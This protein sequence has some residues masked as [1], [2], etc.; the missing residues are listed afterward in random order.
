MT[1]DINEDGTVTNVELSGCI[2]HHGHQVE[3]RYMRKSKVTN[4]VVEALLTSGVPAQ[5]IKKKYF[6]VSKG[7]GDEREKPLIYADITRMAHNII[8]VPS[9][10]K[11][12]KT[13]ALMHVVKKEEIRLFNFASIIEDQELYLDHCARRKLCKTPEDRLLMV[14]ISEFQRK[15]F[16]ENPTQIFVDGKSN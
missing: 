3:Q 4:E 8:P 1:A 16:R 7:Q 12:P 5:T 10:Y 2:A 9:T 14:R 13:E 15:M 11:W 6:A